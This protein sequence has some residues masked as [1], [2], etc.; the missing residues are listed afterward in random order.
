MEQKNYYTL[1]GVKKNASAQQIKE[2]YRHLAFRYHPDR[3]SG[4][5]D[6]NAEQMKA[7]NEAYAVLSNPQKRREYDILL[8]QYGSSAYGQFRQ[9]YTERD[10]FN[11]SD[12]HQIF[13]EMTRSFGFRGFDEIFNEFY[14]SGYRQFEFKRHGYHAKGFSFSG[15]WMSF[16]CRAGGSRGLGGIRRITRFLL[17]HAGKGQEPRR[18]PDLFD[19]INLQSEFAAT[20]G[21]YP[22][23]HRQQAKKIVVKVPPGIKDGQQIRLSGMGGAGKAGGVSGDLY[24]KVKI[25][26]TLLEKAKA[27][28]ARLFESR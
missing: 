14:G 8:Q 13:E 3:N 15:P 21:P 16:R 26:R 2:A 24:L 23:L 28:T 11:G 20:G 22:Y 25:K 9:S 10:I 19:I 4:T 1:L 17:K 6:A 18:G 27:M 5:N 12:I 7:I